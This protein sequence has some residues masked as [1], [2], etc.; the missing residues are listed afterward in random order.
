MLK[1]VSLRLAD[2]GPFS[3]CG[4]K[5]DANITVIDCKRLETGGMML[6][7]RVDGHVDDDFVDDLKR[8][9]GVKHV[10]ASGLGGRGPLVL[11]AL[12]TPLFCE[13]A[14]SSG[15]LCASC[16]LSSNRAGRCGWDV[17]VRD[18]S[19]L[20]KVTRLLEWNGFPAQIKRVSES[21]R[22]GPLTKAH[23]R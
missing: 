7:L 3:A 2:Q 16:P 11:V 18:V 15:F 8:M 9:P 1:Q 12:E 22:D 6:L 23:A 21:T 10:N 13:I 17:L 14:M 20:N 19:D 4:R 5:H